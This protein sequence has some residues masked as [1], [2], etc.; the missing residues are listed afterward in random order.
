MTLTD[1]GTLPISLFWFPRGLDGHVYQIRK[2]PGEADQGTRGSA[3]ERMYH[4]FTPPSFEAVPR[5]SIEDGLVS[6]APITLQPAP[7][8]PRWA[9]A[10]VR[11]AV[12]LV[13]Q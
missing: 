13:S 5:P 11:D 12:R 10:I 9:E 8:P 1:R 4:G 7:N 3:A 6:G 2:A